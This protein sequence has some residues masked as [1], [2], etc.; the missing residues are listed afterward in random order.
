MQAVA[1]VPV[2][3]RL[4]TDPSASAV[5]HGQR[6]ESAQ[7]LVAQATRLIEPTAAPLHATPRRR[8]AALVPV[9]AIVPVVLGLGAL[10]DGGRLLFWDRPLTDAAVAARTPW[11]DDI[12][13]AAS[14]LGSWAVVF[15]AAVLLASLAAVRSRAL[16]RL[17]LVV[18]VARPG[19]EWLLKLIVHCPRPRGARLVPGTG[20]SYPSGHVLAAIATWGFLPA[21]LALYTQRRTGRII[22]RVVAATLIAAIAWSRVWL[23]VHWTSDV[24]GSLAIGVLAFGLAGSWELTP[25][26]RRRAHSRPGR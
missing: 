21:V 4:R 18:M 10:V 15:P 24:V 2:R 16:A 20:F 8:W 9:A 14:R 17:I 11:L 22:A 25:E 19:V 6:A 1:G 26:G 12:A 7:V 13:L 23:G 5:T 3:A